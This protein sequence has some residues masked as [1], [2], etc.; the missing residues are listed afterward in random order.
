M[1]GTTGVN[2]II[3]LS[4]KKDLHR[5]GFKATALI[6]VKSG[7]ILQYLNGEVAASFSEGDTEILAVHNPDVFDPAT[8]NPQENE[9]LENFSVA[10]KELFIMA[11]INNSLPEKICNF[12]ICTTLPT[13]SASRFD[14]DALKIWSNEE[15]FFIA[16]QVER[17]MINIYFW[18][19]LG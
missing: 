6:D 18:S 4:T 15:N 19:K 8:M 5:N 16:A 13:N 9:I 1:S 17:A 2:P 7:K 10:Y 11:R 12:P 14:R 3:F